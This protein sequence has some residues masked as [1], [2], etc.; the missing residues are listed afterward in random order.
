MSTPA[1]AAEIM[2][3][4][5]YSGEDYTVSHKHST[6]VR[7]FLVHWVDIGMLSRTGEDNADGQTGP[8]YKITERGRVWV[9]A[10]LATPYL[11]QSWNIPRAEQG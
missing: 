1:I 4:Y 6:A 9:Q 7:D 8:Q 11:V 5:Y 10:L 2:L 3:H